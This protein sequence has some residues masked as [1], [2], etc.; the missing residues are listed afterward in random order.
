MRKFEAIVLESRV[1]GTTSA[2]IEWGLCGRDGIGRW[3]SRVL[4]LRH[5]QLHQLV[6][7]AIC[8]I[9]AYRL[10]VVFRNGMPT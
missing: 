2:M 7:E 5:P 6:V 9:P 10:M 1:R 4:E 3:S 8:A